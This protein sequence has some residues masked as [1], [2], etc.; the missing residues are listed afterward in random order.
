MQEFLNGGSNI[1]RMI[2]A[3]EKCSGTYL[4]IRLNL[5][6]TLTVLDKES[7]TPLEDSEKVIQEFISH[8]EIMVYGSKTFANIAKKMGLNPGSFMNEKFEFDIF[9][10][11][12]G[13]ELLNYD[14]LIG[15]LWELNPIA[16]TFFIRPTGN[17]KL[18]TGMTVTKEEFRLW[19]KREQLENS[20]YKGESLM[21]SPI[22]EIE[23]EYRFFVVDQQ[24]ITAS[25]Y[26]VGTSIDTSHQPS[27]ALRNYAI[28][29]VARF[30]LA[31]AF[32]ID[33]AETKEG[34]KVIEYNNINSSG[35]Y[36]CDEVALVQA[37]NQLPISRNE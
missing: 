27:V 37:I 2:Q 14:L 13:D 1:L 5:D 18:F 24:I 31:K 11:A 34:F 35:L 25:S 21:I 6:E 22:K 15:D 12:L 3:L 16:A 4:L 9:R 33:I 36:G 32:V 20:L 28:S 29:M 10:E 19:Q 7:K 17:T 30:P 26:K 23:A 8:E